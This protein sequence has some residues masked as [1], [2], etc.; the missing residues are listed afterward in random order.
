[1]ALTR[2]VLLA[3]KVADTEAANLDVL[4]S[5]DALTA[6]KFFVCQSNQYE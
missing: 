4:A 6:N 3:A 1:M 5:L 2:M